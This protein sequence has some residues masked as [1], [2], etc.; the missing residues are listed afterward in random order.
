VSNED[1]IITSGFEPGD[2][3]SA[4]E[5][6]FEKARQI[7]AS[8]G[9]GAQLGIINV[10]VS[11][12]ETKLRPAITELN[13]Q[14]HTIGEGT[15][16]GAGFLSSLNKVKEEINT[17]TKEVPSLL[18]VRDPEVGKSLGT[19]YTQV[20]N[21]IKVE[22]AATGKF[23][24]EQLKLI[25]NAANSTRVTAQRA[26]PLV[27]TPTSARDTGYVFPALTPEQ[28]LQQ[29]TGVKQ[30]QA[31]AEAQKRANAELKAQQ[32]AGKELFSQGVLNGEYLRLNQQYG[33][34]QEG[35]LVRTDLQPILSSQD[36]EAAQRA[37]VTR[38][39]AAQAEQ[40]KLD[41]INNPNP[42]LLRTYLGGATGRGFEAPKTD[43]FVGALA[44]T[45]GVLTKY[46]AAGAG[47]GIATQGLH[48]LISQT[49]TY[50]AALVNLSGVESQAGIGQLSIN[51]AIADGAK[52]GLDAS[53]ALDAGTAGVKNY[54]SAI[55]QGASAQDVFN[56]SVKQ[57][58]IIATITG[59]EVQKA[60]QQLLAVSNAF[61]LSYS[62]QG[63][64][65]DAVLAASRAFNASPTDV[66]SG[67]QSSGDL[68]GVSGFSVASLAA[69]AAAAKGQGA[70]PSGLGRLL[71]KGGSAQ[72]ET[73]LQTLGVQNTGNVATELQQAAGAY[74]KLT[75]AEKAHFAQTIGGARSGDL[76][77]SVLKSQA[78]ITDTVAFANTHAGLAQQEAINQQN[79]LGGQLRQFS[80]DLKDLASEITNTGA[81]TLLGLTFES[82][83]TGLQGIDQALGV[84]NTLPGTLKE[85][86]VGG[87]ELLLVLS[88]LSREGGEQGGIRGGLS[89]LGSF[90]KG[91]LTASRGV[92]ATDVTSAEGTKKATSATQTVR[93]TEA[94]A[95][96]TKA[97]QDHTVAVVSDTEST[98]PHTVAV[99]GDTVSEEENIVAQK[100]GALAQLTGSVGGFLGASR[101]SLGGASIGG[102]AL[103]GGAVAIGAAEINKAI[104][105][106]AGSQ[107]RAIDSINN[108][109]A[110]GINATDANSLQQSAKDASTAASAAKQSSGGVI[111]SYTNFV[112]GIAGLGTT[113]Q[114]AKVAQNQ[115]DTAQAL[116]AQQ[117][118]YNPTGQFNF[119]NSDV[120]TAGTQN[121]KQ[122]GLDPAG[123]VK[124]QQDALAAF[125]KESSEGRSF[126]G[127]GQGASFAANIG[128]RTISQFQGSS[129]EAALGVSKNG[130]P[131]LTAG[132]KSDLAASVTKATNDYISKNKLENT[133]LS[134][135]PE[136][137]KGL[138]DATHA[139]LEQQLATEGFKKSVIAQLAPE[140]SGLAA[141]G[142]QSGRENVNPFGGTNLN[143]TQ[144]GDISNI[145]I[146]SQQSLEALNLQKNTANAG[147][148][149]L[150]DS[151][152]AAL[153]T[154]L[155]NLKTL[156]SQLA[157]ADPGADLSAID[158]E[159]QKVK[160]AQGTA[161]A[162]YAKNAAAFQAGLLA[163]NDV[164]A[165]LATQ[166]KGLTTAAQ[167][168]TGQALQQDLDQAA[169]IK[170]QQSLLSSTTTPISTLLN[171]T[172]SGSAPS[173]DTQA[174]ALAKQ[175]GVS[176]SQLAAVS[177]PGSSIGQAT[178]TVLA[179]QG[180]YN[181]DLKNQ[182]TD[183]NT[184]N[185]D[186]A[187]IAQNQLALAQAQQQDSAAQLEASVA[188]GDV[189]GQAKAQQQA[190]LA[191]ANVTADPGAAA[192]LRRQAAQQGA[193]AA[194]DVTN[195]AGL[196]ALAAIQPG[197]DLGTA[198]Q[199]LANDRA[200][201]ATLR[202]TTPGDLQAI[203]QAQ[204]SINQDIISVVS[205]Y[206]AYAGAVNTSN[207]DQ[208]N[209]VA[210]AQAAARTAAQAVAKDVSTGV[211]GTKLIQD[212][213]AAAAAVSNA[214]QA[215]F[216]QQ[217]TDQQNQFNLHQITASAY[218]NYLDSTR[219]SLK[220]QLTAMKA[221]SQGARQILDELTQ[222][223][224]T[225]LS[226]AN[227]A[228]GQFNLGNINIPT[229]YEVQRS[230]AASGVGAGYNVM[231]ITNNTSIV[232]NGTDLAAVQAILSQ[233]LA[234]PLT[235]VTTAPRK[236]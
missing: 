59:E 223:N 104:Y 40:A 50:E 110:T 79:T 83:K 208:T 26:F 221:G 21:Q 140:L 231:P 12:L 227:Q 128:A 165:N 70:D 220:A 190:L 113:D 147:R 89:T 181:E 99:D 159:I 236:V 217:F 11:Q 56:E 114:A 127:A 179:A 5:A 212:Q 106:A 156:R 121:I 168:D 98:V 96:A 68:A 187:A 172:A 201:L 71:A 32:E 211:G 74:A 15:E 117:K 14:L 209:P 164:A 91:Q 64:V 167:T 60:Q 229:P 8:S 202:S 170:F 17:F 162:T 108:L 138:R 141:F 67:L 52:Y 194:I 2:T 73:G 44:G 87:T 134:K 123:I 92:V 93:F 180:Q 186:K 218:I 188:I 25:G 185:R 53:Q 77:I 81:F 30:T 214:S 115:A 1:F 66:L 29:S 24:A 155:D 4:L 34:S 228:S 82:V 78:Q 7:A 20:F 207:I 43:S 65:S 129:A 216:S 199:Q 80:A 125:I 215:A 225:I 204:Q 72:F 51:G 62:Q 235:T 33:V 137:L 105:N 124:Q 95:V 178:Q 174:A 112:S 135:N 203:A 192:S 166:L 37:A 205:A 101:A 143:Q 222:V 130:N 182:I 102:T 49:E 76:L 118:V 200:K 193:T 75:D 54:S 94:L 45:A 46:A 169:Q 198:S 184:L 119:N 84:F 173:V 42:G 139:A 10:L 136:A 157:A 154:Q 152:G 145:G 142:V 191:Q 132:Q 149:P 196:Q 226:V 13:E 153:T 122:L 133:D 69:T 88:A 61:N 206:T 151:E 120:F 103:I 232:I 230:I 39:A 35:R 63:Q 55:A 158:D 111:G 175:A 9:D 160:L 85:I 183:Q 171:K 213:N 148:N 161:L 116:A 86:V 47:I 58:G 90:I 163:P 224:Q 23:A 195:I 38:L 22:A 48:E 41:N 27:Q 126:L 197:N 107:S 131:E 146:S 28:K 176:A 233:Y 18:Q 177:S 109:A 150:V 36:Q 19:A 3:L 210:V 144:V 57:A 100:G 189:V 97:I 16:V 6:M 219:D 234:N 31:E